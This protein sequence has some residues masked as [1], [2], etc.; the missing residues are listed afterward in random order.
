[1][2]E[3]VRCTENWTAKCRLSNSN[4][5]KSAGKTG[6]TYC[7]L[8]AGEV[9]NPRTNLIWSRA[10]PFLGVERLTNWPLPQTS[11]LVAVIH[12]SGLLKKKLYDVQPSWSPWEEAGQGGQEGKGG[13][14]QTPLLVR[15]LLIIGIGV[16]CLQHAQMILASILDCFPFLLLIIRILP[17]KLRYRLVCFVNKHNNQWGRGA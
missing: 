15:T 2:V 7:Q 14:E 1:M 9:F 17:V 11:K 13:G 8:V 3:Q 16:Y 5:F 4:I 12:S 10:P 6:K